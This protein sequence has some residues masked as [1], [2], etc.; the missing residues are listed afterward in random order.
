[1]NF[2][3]S[4][5]KKQLSIAMCVLMVFSLC[6]CN[7]TA[8]DNTFTT[9]DEALVESTVITSTAEEETL[10]LSTAKYT[11]GVVVSEESENNTKALEGFESAFNLRDTEKSGDHH[12]IFVTVCDGEEESCKK[13][14]DKYVKSG[15]DLIFAIGE[16]AAIASAEATDTIPIIFCSVYDPIKAELLTSSVNPDKNVTGVSDYTPAKQQMELIRELLPDAKKVSSLYCSTDADSILISTLA[17]NHAEALRYDFKSYG[18]A[19]DKQFVTALKDALNNA[20]VLYLCDGEITRKNAEVIFKEA[21]KKKIPVISSSMNFMTMGAFAT[22]LPDY[23]ELGYSAG[24]LALICVKDLLPV[25]EIAVEYPESSIYYVSE[26]AA[27]T[28]SID[29]TRIYNAEFLK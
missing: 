20:D 26:S 28:N 12:S 29:I 1:M 7:N 14:A 21:N 15:V 25:S 6:A 18:A 16:T 4:T 11:I 5:F 9:P 22:A 10:P 27:K 17:Q 2:I 3:L 23:S 8:L 19:D 24:E 13:A